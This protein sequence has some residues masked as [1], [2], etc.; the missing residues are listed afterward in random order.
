MTTT[1]VLALFL[2]TTAWVLERTFRDSVI[3]N[4]EEQLRLVIYS[5]MSAV[6][7]ED[8]RLVVNDNL[9]QPRLSLPES[10]LY[11]QLIDDIAGPLWT[12][13]SAISESVFVADVAGDPGDFVFVQR[14][15]VYVLSYSVFWEGVENERVTFVAVTDQTPY[16]AAINQFR[17]NLGVGLGAATLVFI[18]AQIFAL[19]W[20]LRP[21][22]IMAQEVRALESG[23]RERLSQGYPTE[24]QGLADN[25]DRF[26]EHEHRSRTRYR[27]AL[28]DLAHSLKTPLAVVRNALLDQTPDK[29][30]LTDQLERME[31]T[32]QHQLSKASAQGPV[33]VGKPV[34]IAVLVGRIMTA[35]KTA[36]VDRSIETRTELSKS[37]FARGDERDFM[38]L[39]GNLIENAFKYTHDIVQVA[40]ERANGMTCVVIQDNGP[41]IPQALRADVLDRGKRL[42]EMQSGQGIGLSMV[43]ELVAL[44]KG[45]LTI[46]DSELGGAKITVA[47]Q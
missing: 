13:P 31:S 33:V 27:N 8:G 46:D 35:L 4:A 44:Y 20:G 23:E 3:T 42:D 28:D 47:L 43:A 16:V 45:V 29:A 34:D 10:G 7:E 24:L 40:V 39:F 22:S 2:A 6:D 15:G 17:R 41:G 21:L 11:A 5:V 19:R 18:L 38:E 1:A 25:L 32:V 9:A 30:L 14:A 26:V 12:S 36:Y 37:C